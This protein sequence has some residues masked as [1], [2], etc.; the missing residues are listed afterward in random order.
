MCFF[1]LGLSSFGWA[2]WFPSDVC[3]IFEQIDF[4]LAQC[5]SVKSWD[6]TAI[7]TI[8]DRGASESV[9]IVMALDMMFAGIDTSSH[10]SAYALYQ[11]AKHPEI[12]ETLYK[13]IKS[14]LPTKV[15]KFS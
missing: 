1:S 5:S 2:A 8:F 12:Q 13:E 15:S 10:T 3:S 9:A 14:E 6:Q 11:L 4:I 7:L